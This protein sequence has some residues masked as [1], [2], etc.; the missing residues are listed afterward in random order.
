MKSHVLVTAV[1]LL[2]QH[3]LAQKT[4]G[5][6]SRSSYACTSRES[7]SYSFCDKAL[8]IDERVAD[9]I[10]R[11][12]LEEKISQLGNGADAISS[13]DVPAYQ[14]WGEALHGVA[15]CPSVHW[16]GPVKGAT[17]FPMPI[18]LAAS[19]NKSLWNKIGQVCA[20]KFHYPPEIVVILPKSKFNT[21]LS[22]SPTGSFASMHHTRGGELCILV[23]HKCWIELI[24]M[25]LLLKISDENK[26]WLKQKP[27]TSHATRKNSTDRMMEILKY[28]SSTL[29]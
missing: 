16:D 6:S 22:I 10:S 7:K 12:S 24:L 23:E 21:S 26:G 17:S 14:W 13:V 1:L 20:L 28:L 9:L 29:R 8:S 19:F 18:S 25:R 5:D 3:L 27:C 4:N 2:I 15:Y 11:L